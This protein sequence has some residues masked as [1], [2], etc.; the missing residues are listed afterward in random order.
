[1]LT[2]KSIFA[3]VAAALKIVSNMVFLFVNFAAVH[4]QLFVR[5]HVKSKTTTDITSVLYR[6]PVLMQRKLLSGKALF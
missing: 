3:V 2:Y 5:K 1:M 4:L 6:A